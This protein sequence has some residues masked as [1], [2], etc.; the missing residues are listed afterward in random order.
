[1]D[2]WSTALVSTSPCCCPGRSKTGPC[3]LLRPSTNRGEDGSRSPEER[4][5]QIRSKHLKLKASNSAT[6][7]GC[8]GRTGSSA[9]SGQ[10]ATGL[11]IA[12]RFAV[13]S[14]IW[15]IDDDLRLP[16]GPAP[17]KGRECIT[18]WAIWRREVAL[19]VSSLKPPD[20]ETAWRKHTYD[21]RVRVVLRNI[22]TH[23]LLRHR[24]IDQANAGLPVWCNKR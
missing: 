2:W 20:C 22:C 4:R 15:R 16:P 3:N 11:L 9:W 17:G 6:P 23:S 8:R 14:P 18:L 24:K 19:H 21:S 10:R 1:M 5:P 12:L 7:A 13:D